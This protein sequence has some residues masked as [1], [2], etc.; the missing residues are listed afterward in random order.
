MFPS[1]QQTLEIIPS[2]DEVLEL[3]EDSD[4]DESVESHLSFLITINEPVSPNRENLTDSLFRSSLCSVSEY[5][6]R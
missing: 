5:R 6:Y 2:L 3:I 4:L 1:D